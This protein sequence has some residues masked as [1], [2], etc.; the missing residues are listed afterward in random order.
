MKRSFFTILNGTAGGGRCRSRADVALADLEKSGHSLDVHLTENPGHATELAS[1]AYAEGH[2]NFLSVGGDGTSFEIVNGLFARDVPESVRLG[3]LPLGTGNSFM[4]DFGIESSDDALAAIK[5][6]ETHRIDVIRAVHRDGTLYY[7]NTM[8][9]GFVAKAGAL[10]NERFK[11]LGAGG[12]VAAVLTSVVTLD[13]P[14][15][16]LKINGISE[17]DRRPAA[18]ISF[19]NS[20]YTGGA[21]KMAPSADVQDGKLDVVRVGKL[22]RLAFV[23][24]FPKIFAGTHIR[25]PLI[26]ETQARRVDF[27]EEY[28]QPLLVDGELMHLAM[29]HLEVLPSAL[30]VYA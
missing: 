12:Y 1:Q 25:H 22:P 8:G 21:M 11:P 9:I 29:R 3:I 6:G 13:Y 15:D 30:Q 17:I 24:T 16:A 7:I 28:E 2:R 5:K 14:I 19:S 27:V 26:E 4:R 23:A 10:T 20:K 18:M